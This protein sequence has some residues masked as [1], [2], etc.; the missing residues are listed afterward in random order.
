[1]TE[2]KF[3]TGDYVKLSLLKRELKGTIIESPDSLTIL[4]KLESGYNIGI[5]KEKI[6]NLKVLKKFKEEKINSKIPFSKN[7]KNIGMIVTGGTIASRLDPKTGGVKPF[8]SIEEFSTFYPEVFKK[9]NVK[10]LEMPFTESSENMTWKHWKD[11][12][13]NVK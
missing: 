10:K 3:N 1:M 13:K 5:P 8:S 4:L 9:V 2:L 6:L 7:K 12:R 11:I